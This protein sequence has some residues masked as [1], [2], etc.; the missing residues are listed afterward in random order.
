MATEPEISLEAKEEF[1]SKMD[2]SAL[3]SQIGLWEK[4]SADL[5]EVLKTIRETNLN[6]YHGKQTDVDKISGKESK[7]VENRV[8]MA[9]ETAIPIVTARLP[10]MVVKPA[11]DAEMSQLDAYELQDILAYQFEKVGIQAKAERFT[12]DMLLKRLGVFKVKWDN[13]SDDLGLDQIDPKRIH[14]PKFGKSVIDLA[15]VIE[16]MELSYGQMVDVFGEE[17]AGK[18]VREHGQT[19]VD[20]KVRKSTYL[21][22]E[23]WTNYYVCWKTGGIILDKKPNPYW[24]EGGDN[25]L[26]APTKPYVIKSLFETDE[27]LVGSTDYVTQLKTVQDNINTRKRQ[28]EDV[29]GKTANPNLLID[30]D[31][32]SEEEANAITNQP[33][34]ILYGKDAA[35]PNKIRFENPG[36]LPNYVFEDLQS[37]RQEFDN[38]FG[39]HSSTRGERQG[40]ETATGRNLLRDADLGRIDLIGRQIERALDEVAELWVQLIKINYTEERAFTI[41]GED[42]MRFVKNF[43]N[44][45]VQNGMRPSVKPGSTLKES[46]QD[47]KQNGIILWQNKAI[48]LKTL[49]K[50]LKLPNMAEAIQD[51]QQTFGQGS[52]QAPPQG[53]QIPGMNVQ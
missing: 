7:A 51:F 52:G 22:K 41:A 50:M 33:G 3:L 12:R 30:S 35:N 21:V 49:Y 2:D 11:D 10:D 48:G 40:R 25:Y 45:K 24:R 23:V 53:E 8:F 1:T 13:A 26:D 14:I 44:K 31:V 5:D 47:I 9:V 32:M 42:G 36:Q 20:D 37:S 15:F 18:A 4:E 19:E 16:D 34:A 38:I 6:Y 27:S 39:L 46:E 43:S 29:A 17:K 28:I